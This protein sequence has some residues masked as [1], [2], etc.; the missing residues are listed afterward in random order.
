MGKTKG[1]VAAGHKITA[2]TAKEILS[3]G[4]N[5]FDAIV[6]A[7]F[8][9]CVTEPVLASLAGG[10]YML[11]KEIGKPPHIY[12]FFVQTPS[13]KNI[14]STPDFF[15][16][17]ADFG[18][19]VQEFHIGLGSIAVPGSVRG[20]FKIHR[21]LCTLPMSRLIQPAI[22]AAKK[23]VH[24]SH[25]QAKIFEI[26]SPIYSATPEAR[27]TYTG[28][29]RTNKL[30]GENDLLKQPKLAETLEDLS[31]QGERLFYEGEIAN[32]IE[33]LCIEGGGYITAKD[34]NNYRVIVRE[35]SIISYRNTQLF[36]NPPPASG[37]ILIALALKLMEQNNFASCQFGS[38]SHLDF[39]A[40]VMAE[41]N[42]ARLDMLSSNQHGLADHLLDEK[43]V[44][45]YKRQVANRARCLRGT[46]HISVIDAKGNA[47]AMT[48]SNGE[49]CG[50]MVPGTG[51]MLNNMLGEED[52]NPQ[53]FHCWPENQRMTSMMSP[54]LLQMDKG[55]DKNVLV[56]L[57]SGGSN[58][59][60]TAM[61]QVISNLVDF[62]MTPE[63]AVSAP[64]IHFENDLLNIEPGFLD[65][66]LRQL[67]KGYKNQQHWGEQNLFF[68]GVHSVEYNG[69]S[70]RTAGDSR[71]DGVGVIVQ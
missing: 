27:Q 10:G 12:D 45:H 29:V 11:G 44:S 41:T 18:T 38:S 39:L 58:R 62:G 60:R 14:S 68:G 9:A 5:A 35:P 54:S 61:L 24:F 50:Y 32:K 66:Q 6:A 23:G 13:N 48:V 55:A 47:A 15:P 26:V 53:G 64:R 21:D 51:I 2:D 69:E 59:I 49:G 40:R 28:S 63:Q 56:A 20:M 57:G 37:G 33:Q 8:T 16:I 30:V 25:L 7:H 43:Y 36:T 4:G 70:F 1:A 19:T 42:Q 67:N 31:E 71:R 22:N 46:T 17:H 52:I 34:L 3:E 65:R